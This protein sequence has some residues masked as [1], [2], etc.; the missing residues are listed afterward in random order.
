MP[1]NLTEENIIATRKTK[2]VYKI[3]NS[4]IKLFV[5]NYS[6]SKILNEALNQAKIEEMTDLNIAKLEEVTTINGRW[7]L[8]SEHIDGK[9]LEELMNEHPE[10]TDEY[11]ELFVRIQLE[12]L[13][14]RIPLI[15]TMKEKYKRKINEN[16]TIDNSIKYELLQRLE[17]IEPHE[18]LC[19]G[20]FN[21]SNIILKENGE[22]YIID[23]AHVT[24]GNTSADVALTYLLF[25]MQGKD[26]IAEKYFELFTKLSGMNIRLIQ[27][28]IPIVAATQLEKYSGEEE[29][30]LRSWINVAEY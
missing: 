13:D 24:K 8:V 30:F 10:R 18:Y 23:W 16:K 11:L 29:K 5:E 22:H 1:Y 6:K 15:N 3:E 21:P 9:S 26:E 4:T 25:K 28:W 2:T 14:K 27:R 12:V 7:A 20:D 19:H 17:G